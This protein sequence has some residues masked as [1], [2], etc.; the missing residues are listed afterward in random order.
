MRRYG[1]LVDPT[2]ELRCLANFRQRL[3]LGQGSALDKGSIF[4]MGDECG[5][6]GR[7]LIGENV[8]VGPYCFL[9]SCHDLEIG[10]NTLIG[11]HSYIITVNHRT[12]Q[13][14]LPVSRQGYRGASIKIGKNVWIGA[15]VVVLPG[16]EIG[17]NAV[18]GA[19]AVVTKSV[20][21]RETWLGVPARRL[22]NR[23]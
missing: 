12:D 1:R 2:V 14:V 3:S 19:G 6:V 21:P 8:Y 13:A 4:W 9:G 10:E 5:Q 17:D 18:I 7:I 11:A 16:V 15:N 20:P 23:K 22:D